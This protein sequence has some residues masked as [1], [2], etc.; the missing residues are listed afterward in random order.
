MNKTPYPD[1]VLSHKGKGVE[2]RHF[3]G[4]YYLYKISSFW[5]KEKQKTRKKTECLLGRILP[6][7][8]VDSKRRVSLSSL[9]NISVLEYGMSTYLYEQ[10]ADILS[11]LIK[12]FPSNGS[13]LFTLALL[14]L[15]YESPLKNMQFYYEHAYIKKLLPDIRIG[16]NQLSDLLKAVG[17]DRASISNCLQSLMGEASCLLVDQTHVLSLSEQMGCNRLGYNSQHDFAPQVNLLFLFSAE[18]KTPLY[19]RMLAGDIRETT[20]LKM[21][22]YESGL[23]DA[24]IIGDKGFYSQTNRENLQQAGLDY[25]LPLRRNHTLCDYSSIEQGDKKQFSGYFLF[26]DRVI[27]YKKQVKDGQNILLFLDERLKNQEEK[28]YLSRIETSENYAEIQNEELNEGRAKDD[29]SDITIRHTDQEQADSKLDQPANG[30]TNQAKDKQ[31]KE[32]NPTYSIEK[33]YEKQHAMGTITITYALKTPKSAEQIFT[34]F[35]SRNEIETA[36]DV[37]KNVL[38]ADKTYMQGQ[39]QMETW[40]FINFMALVMYYR[41]Y[42]QLAAQKMLKNYTPKDIILFLQHIKKIYINGE[43]VQAELTKKTQKIINLL[44]IEGS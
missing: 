28:D 6:E 33:F 2:I 23:Q 20:A 36:F 22:L 37:Y 18:Q 38:N 9:D 26:E 21:T 44:R 1:W 32:T 34:C 42:K 31:T 12:H 19:Y 13:C 24:I 40:S 4:R 11:S 3:K 5:D 43:W 30:D 35:K 8:L 10:N 7:G 17:N 39:A 29:N 14:R 41:I 25:I 15:G 27:W 16:K